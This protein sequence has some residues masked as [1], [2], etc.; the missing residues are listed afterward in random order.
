MPNEAMYFTIIFYVVNDYV[1]LC[2]RICVAGVPVDGEFNGCVRYGVTRSW[3]EGNRL[4]RNGFADDQL[5][6]DAK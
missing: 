5:L 1:V 3:F 6:V 4:T 2:I